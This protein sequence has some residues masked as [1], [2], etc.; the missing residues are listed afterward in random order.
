MKNLIILLILFSSII[1][2][3]TSAQGH[4]PNYVGEWYQNSARGKKPHK[5]SP[6]SNKPSNYAQEKKYN[7]KANANQLNSILNTKPEYLDLTIPYGD[8]SYTLNLAK[9]DVTAEGFS[10]KT[11]KGNVNHDKGVQY[12][13][14][15]NN[16]PAHIASL[17]L[18]KTDKSGFFST[19]DGNFVLTDEGV[20]FI[21]YNEQEIPV[22]IDIICSTPDVSYQIPVMAELVE[23]VGCKTVKVYFECD[24]AFYQSKGS[25]VTA[26]TDYVV[27]FFNQVATIYANED[28]SIQ[29][30]EIFTW[31]VSDPYVAKTT[32]SDIMNTF[33]TNRGTSFNGNIAHF[34]STRTPMG[35][36]A[37][38]DALCNKAY[39]Y[40]VSRISSTYQNFPTYSWTVN[41]VAH[42]LG[43]TVASPHTHS[44][45]WSGGALD[46]CATPD[47][48]CSPGPAPVNGGTIMSY[49]HTTSAGINF[50]NGF[51]QQPGNLIRSKV[52]N[53]SCIVAG[54]TSAAPT[55]LSTTNITASSATLNWG[56]VPGASNYTV[57]YKLA[58][59]STWISTGVTTSTNANISGLTGSSNYVWQVKTDCSPFSASTSFTT[60]T[61][62]GTTCSAPTQLGSNNITTSGVQLGW[63]AV[64]GATSYT[65]QYRPTSSSTWTTIN[66]TTNAVS[67]AGLTAGTL[68]EWQVKAN[69]S[70]YSSIANFVTASGSTDPCI[71][72]TQL[73]SNNITQTGVQMTWGAVNGATGYTVQYKPSNSSTWSTLTTTTNYVSTG[74]LS[75]ATTYQWQV[76]TNCSPYSALA[77][78]TTAS[79]SSGC[80]VPSG[81]GSANISQ[82]GATLSWSAVSGATGY[83]VQYKK[84]SVSTWTTLNV[85]TTTTT[86]SGL[87]SGTTYNWQVKASCSAYSNQASF[88]TTSTQVT[89]CTIPTNLANTNI[90]GTSATLSWTGPANAQT[91]QVRYKLVGASG[92]TIRNITTPSL[93]I[94]GL[95]RNR[96]YQWMVNTKCTNGTSSSFSATKTFT[97]AAL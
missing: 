76:K 10:V 45:S 87:A 22:P 32:N 89:G 88:T 73:G 97:T 85:S 90:T 51:G 54:T 1:P 31:T 40:G 46:N 19:D 75:P 56:A 69:C 81:L 23:G 68:Y 3:L 96:N 20:D 43:H 5:A 72:P 8:R 91:Y 71:A 39:A 25:N 30:S 82:S 48:T 94:T 11:N 33:R 70:G 16:N 7:L 67:F 60:T 66:A 2:T 93:N 49:C 24:Y 62:G 50:N 47:G 84:S 6:F 59:A 13:G 15:V 95:L 63:G 18:T 65:V 53:A 35:G 28:V 44:C 38:V 83:T 21:V 29:I 27:G 77:S 55:S 12:R 9:V 92:W 52:Q 34:L 78:F 58:T 17:S 61:S 4:K 57:Q 42:E 74:N 80:S 86:L 64:T 37:Y 41:V 36:I 14:I 26:V 79:A